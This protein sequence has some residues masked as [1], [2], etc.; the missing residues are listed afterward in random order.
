MRYMDY[1]NQRTRI[2]DPVRGTTV[3]DFKA[4]KSLSVVHNGTHDVCK[5]YCPIDSEDTLDGGQAYFVETNATDKGATTFDGK[6]V[7]Q[8]EWKEKILKIV[9]MS[10]TDFYADV[11]GATVTPVAQ[12]QNLTPFGQ[13]IGQS[14]MTWTSFTAG[15]QPAAKFD[16]QGADTCPQDPQCGQQS[17]Q[18]HRLMTGQRHTFARYFTKQ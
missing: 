5:S 17:K 2:D 18:L 1:T 16:I 11:S 12:V 7:N 13:H 4:H 6:A 3:D 14:N 9:T 8:W 15:A 10:T